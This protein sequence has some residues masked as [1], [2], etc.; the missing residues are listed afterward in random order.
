MVAATVWNDASGGRA[1]KQKTVEKREG[2]ETGFKRAEGGSV[3]AA[4]AKQ[5]L[6]NSLNLHMAPT[7]RQQ[8]QPQQKQ[9]QQSQQQQQQQKQQQRQQ[10]QQ[11]LEAAS[12]KATRSAA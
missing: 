11:Q 12:F 4:A 7:E 2:G 5:N 9:Q 6:I 3:K 10:Q 8:Q 1:T